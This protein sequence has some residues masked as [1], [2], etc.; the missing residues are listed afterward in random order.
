MIPMVYSYMILSFTLTVVLVFPW[1]FSEQQIAQS[2]V[3]RSEDGATKF[4]AILNQRSGTGK[5]TIKTVPSLTYTIISSREGLYRQTNS[6]VAF[7][8]PDQLPKFSL[9]QEYKKDDNERCTI[10]SMI[11]IGSIALL[12]GISARRF[13]RYQSKYFC[14]D[15]NTERELAFDIASTIIPDNLDYETFASPWYLDDLEKFD[16]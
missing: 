9:K 6:S 3:K 5:K 4:S 16:V 14:S 13:I 8:T 11:S 10:H 15:V 7:P 1:L 2:R 12:F